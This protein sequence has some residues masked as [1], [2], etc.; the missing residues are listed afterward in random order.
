MSP[1]GNSSRPHTGVGTAGASA[2]SRRAASTFGVK[3]HGLTTALH[4]VRAGMKA[5]RQTR[6][7]YRKSF[8]KRLWRR[9]AEVS[10]SEILFEPPARPP[11][12]RL[13]APGR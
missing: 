11:N 13:A 8:E 10:A 6:S 3:R 12:S 9:F 1:V 7:S 4:N 5:P 2:S